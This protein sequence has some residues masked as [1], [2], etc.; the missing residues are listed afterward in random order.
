[1]AANEIKVGIN[2]SDN[3][4]T[5]KAIKSAKDLKAAYDA[6]A[7]S[8][9][10]M[11]GTA[12]SRMASQK[13]TENY[14]V[15]RGVT[16]RTG[17]SARD[18]A[19]EA[20]GLGGL[21]RLYAT[22]AANVF[23]VGAAFRAL[24]EAAGTEIITRG[25]E[26]MGAAAGRNLVGMARQM[27]TLT[28]GAINLR[29]AMTSV[30]QS[31]AAGL[32]TKQMSDL[33]TVANKASNALGI[34]MSD[35]INRLSRGITKIEPELLDELGIFVRVDKAAQ[36]YAT[37]VGKSVS[38]LSDF[39]RRQS[40]AN[41]VLE[42]GK[43]KF[44]EIGEVSNPYDKLLASIENLSTGGL[45]LV[46]KVLEPIARVLAESPGALVGIAAVLAATIVKSAIPA[47]GQLRLGLRYAAEDSLK[48]AEKFQESFG[49]KF[50][51][52]LEKRFNLDKLRKQ[53]AGAFDDLNKRLKSDLEKISTGSA[54]SAVAARVSRELEKQNKILEEQSTKQNARKKAEAAAI[55]E[56]INLAKQRGQAEQQAQAFADKKLAVLDSE[57]LEYMKYNKLRDQATKNSIV[58]NAA[59]NARVV[60]LRGSWALLNREIAENGIQG[61]A[62]WGTVARGVTAA[63]LSRVGQI[64][65][66]VGGIAQGFAVAV[67]VYQLL[68]GL[69]SSAAKQQEEYN[70]AIESTNGA[71]KTAKDT[72]ELYINKR[73][74]AFS[75]EAVTAFAN[76][77]KEVTSGLDAGLSKL[78]EWTQASGPWDKFKDG[79]KDLFGFGNMDVLR[80]QFGGAI[81]QILSTT[82]FSSGGTR[83]QN[84]IASALG[85]S[86]EDL[87]NKTDLYKEK[88]NSLGQVE[89]SKLKNTLSSISQ[90]EQN[91][92]Q[93]AQ[94]FK[95][96]LQ[97]VDKLITELSRSSRLNSTEAKLGDS[98][99]GAAAKLSNALKDPLKS[100]QEL[101]SL[102]KSPAFQA[103]GVTLAAPPV[104]SEDLSKQL[105]TVTEAKA[106]VKELQSYSLE[107][108][109]GSYTERL[110]DAIITAGAAQGRLDSMRKAVTDYVKTNM[111]LV[112]KM[113]E[114]GLDFAKQATKYAKEQASIA[115]QRSNLGV[116]SA[117]GADTARQE[118][119]LALREI[120]IQEKLVIA[121]F[122]LEQAIVENTRKMQDNTTMM[123]YTELQ[124]KLKTASG[125]EADNI[126]MILNT[127]QTAFD[128]AMYRSS[129]RTIGPQG[130]VAVGAGR[131]VSNAI[132]KQQQIEDRQREEYRAAALAEMSAKRIEVQNQ[133]LLKTSGEDLKNRQEA[134]ALEARDIELG[135]QKLK[136]SQELAGITS[137]ELIDQESKLEFDKLE[138]SLQKELAAIEKDR[139]LLSSDIAKLSDPVIKAR[140]QELDAQERVL[141][142]E[143]SQSKTRQGL[144]DLQKRQAVDSKLY[145]QNQEIAQGYVDLMFDSKQ[146][147]LEV[148]KELV[149]LSV[150]AGLLSQ[151]D[152]ARQKALLDSKTAQQQYDQELY[153]LGTQNSQIQF[154]IEQSKQKE[155][156]LAN[157]PKG[158]ELQQSQTAA[159][160]TQL[161]LG[162]SRINQLKTQKSVTDE[163]V[164]KQAEWN[165]FT[166]KQA[167]ALE[168][169][170]EAAQLLA[171]AF[172]N[173][174]S[175]IGGMATALFKQTQAQE[176]Y[177]EQ[178]KL[179]AGDKQA[180]EKA[181]EEL[182]KSELQ[183]NQ[184]LLSSTKKLFD[185]KSKGYK[186]ISGLEKLQALET[187]KNQATMLMGVVSS[188]GKMVSAY[189]PGVVAAFS[190]VLGPF[191]PPAA[192]ALLGALMGGAFGGGGGV[193]KFSMSSQQ[194]QETQGTGSTYVGNE[195]GT[196][197]LVAT[198][199]GVFGDLKA[200]SES[201]D[202]TLKLMKENQATGIV[203]NDRLYNAFK[204]L[205][206]S[207]LAVAGSLP[208]FQTSIFGTSTG[209]IKDTVLGGLLSS[210]TVNTEVVSSG[211]YLKG[212]FLDLSKSVKNLASIFETTKTTTEDSYLFGLISGGTDVSF[213]TKTTGLSNNQQNLL[214]DMFSV[215]VD[216]LVEVAGEVGIGRTI[217]ESVLDA[218]EMTPI[219]L[220]GLSLEDQASA[221]KSV[222]GSKLADA[223][224][225]LFGANFIN[226]YRKAGEDALDTVVRVLDQNDKISQIAVNIGSL[227]PSLEGLYNVTDQLAKNAGDLNN[228][229]DQY[230]YFIDNFFTS[231][232]K[233]ALSTKSVT[234]ELSKLGLSQI[235]TKA[236]FKSYVQA[237]D[238]TIPA[239]QALYQGLMDLAPAFNEVAT[240]TEKALESLKSK[241]EKFTESLID[242][243]DSLILGSSSTL[244]PLQK[245][246]ESRRQ[247]ENTY[248]KALSGD[249]KA[250]SDL[251][252]AADSFLDAS[253]TYNASS[254][255]Y[256]QDFNS[257]LDKVNNA[258]SYSENQVTT[259]ELQLTES[260]TQ[261]EILRN[262]DKAV[263]ATAQIFA[264]ATG[265]TETYT[266]STAGT[267]S[268]S[269]TSGSTSASAASASTSSSG[270]YKASDLT[271][272]Q[273]AFF[274][275]LDSPEGAI[276]KD[277]RGEALGNA[278]ATVTRGAFS[279]LGGQL[280]GAGVG[281]LQYAT[282]AIKENALT[283]FEAD[284][285]AKAAMDNP[286]LQN[287]ITA[288]LE[289]G[290][291]QE[292]I[293]NALVSLK[294]EMAAEASGTSFI[295]DLLGNGNGNIDAA[296]RALETVANNLVVE[297]AAWE[298]KVAE[299]ASEAAK[300][301]Q[302]NAA[303]EGNGS[304]SSTSSDN[305]ISQ[306]DAAKNTNLD[307]LGDDT[308][309]SFASGG[310]AYRGLSIVGE[311]G[312]ELVDF[313]TPG[314][315]Y[316]AEE[317]F[318]MFNG[319]SSANQ[320]LIEEIRNL[321]KEVQELR[322]QQ[323]EETG[324]LVSATFDSQKNTSK[325][326]SE[327][328]KST[329]STSTW[330]T[331]LQNSVALV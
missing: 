320:E 254:S 19:N 161:V 167:D 87:L 203:Q 186:V 118:T 178:L 310:L 157:D 233:L 265:S 70:S 138:N 76:S 284:A 182:A 285:L 129:G 48:A 251:T 116:L 244:T 196:G 306:S 144:V 286:T 128:A 82:S 281:A 78:K 50:Q 143:N 94:A 318:G 180:E 185:E 242:Y 179:A 323:E 67:G 139:K 66:A 315:V 61:L 312:P 21:V 100:F 200:K 71:V 305:R 8:A 261:T 313:Q 89:L 96:S 303:A 276:F 39:E 30:A 140:L 326:L 263:S 81:D 37:S 293:A 124:S 130:Q 54:S 304:S 240:E 12:G 114:R 4:T 147:Q 237:L 329:S 206:D 278:I 221:I 158:L 60:G 135:L 38:A 188:V 294:G 170:T 235:K 193:P 316:T 69:L 47:I 201:I 134:I 183:T 29:E 192:A 109:D 141:R 264:T 59:E 6:A 152:A 56:S 80:E 162:E 202:N 317:T 111:D 93:S 15:S 99:A 297:T 319:T 107:Q 214:R 245:Y 106:A 64:L 156:A 42:Q 197:R 113:A 168:K 217:V 148:E 258:I 260:E 321:R 72:L 98:L 121:N 210:S 65:G 211:L 259:A 271:A 91:A 227:T 32:T 181:K 222:I 146:K 160:Q 194:L 171:D 213:D 174:G 301:A 13:A 327:T 108:Q 209:T 207:I 35:A 277:I 20:Q 27:V 136:T 280:V 307:S 153:K 324:V 120:A 104:S 308:V 85:L 295:G 9:S 95:D 46:N 250:M 190:A 49:D 92:A 7:K 24:R 256:T 164:Q 52:R 291:P 231:E 88:L 83:Y 187:L 2:V 247:F 325:E 150:Q 269:S 252:S 225:A 142:N 212:S 314:R 274:D 34:N 36:D 328:I 11:G 288:A 137:R 41:A 223:T 74:D 159:L 1:M 33:A 3:G 224:T 205:D 57:R 287:A 302:E 232:E 43:R 279:I 73:S 115:I 311:N 273:E 105:K 145:S 126:R 131:T 51:D 117:A 163:L 270:G 165:I 173:A 155:L 53:T 84:Q 151:E 45:N 189:A 218:I 79:I 243:K 25:L 90:E 18:F 215:G 17:A 249:E 226:A 86:T 204:K 102:S 62:G 292:T 112:G 299:A 236:Q 77:L 267:S 31:S 195:D 68:D 198:G 119:A 298:Q 296:N 75:V 331:K 166:A 22:Y 322:K 58:A 246:E 266:P 149:N 253:K 125:A 208:N 16:G 275:F 282:G 133:G 289:A 262:I 229:V 283:V 184:Q 63:V 40:F 127:M 177:Q 238:L 103:I 239:Q 97:E 175:A 110:S 330:S 199:G 14:G 309:D 44:Q 10:S 23:A 172:G 300:Q 101:E 122:N 191:G 5:N 230:Q 255:Q 154:Q 176:R 228:F 219:D 169:Q 234:A 248:L 241:F 26:T 257:V 28:D 216:A 123:Q 268:G 55:V 290:V 220:Q 272:D 132:L